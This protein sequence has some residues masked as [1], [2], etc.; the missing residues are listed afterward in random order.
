MIFIR[1]TKYN[2]LRVEPHATL[3][4]IPLRTTETETA[5]KKPT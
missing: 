3:I 4:Y 5:A 2:L 1:D